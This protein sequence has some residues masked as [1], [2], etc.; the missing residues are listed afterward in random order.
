MQDSSLMQGGEAYNNIL[1]RVRQ[2]MYT[3]GNIGPQDRFAMPSSYSGARGLS[4]SYGL[5]GI[6][7]VTNRGQVISNVGMPVGRYG[8]AGLA[9]GA[10]S[11]DG[12]SVS[13]AMS[14]RIGLS[15][16]G[17]MTDASGVLGTQMMPQGP[18][19]NSRAP[20]TSV[21][22]ISDGNGM[23]N[24]GMMHDMHNVSSMS[25]AGGVQGNATN[26]CDGS[27]GINGSQANANT[28]VSE[29]SNQAVT[30]RIHDLENSDGN[31]DR[32]SQEMED[33]EILND[34]ENSN[35]DEHGD[36][37]NEA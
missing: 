9:G 31:I 19:T 1:E 21:N 14:D 30:S 22:Q 7:G 11:F 15:G 18:R 8:H 16:M 10:T 24:A 12:M 6:S 3:A 29:R 4:G 37:S 27:I 35:I 32:N 23:S 5:S 28:G 36:F 26:G 20:M 33:N 17:M 25:L 2:T 13:R 34:V